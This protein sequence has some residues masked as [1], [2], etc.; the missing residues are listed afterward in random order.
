MGVVLVLIGRAR[1]AEGKTNG[2][3][4]D[5]NTVIN[6]TTGQTLLMWAAENGHLTILRQSSPSRHL[7][8]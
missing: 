7:F 8:C 1:R 4:A 5:K 2:K 6:K 3:G